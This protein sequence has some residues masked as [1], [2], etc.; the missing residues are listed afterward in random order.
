MAERF[1]GST[2]HKRLFCKMFV[3]THIPFKT[4]DISWPELDPEAT[5]RLKA[6]PIWTEA[7]NTELETGIKVKSLGESEKD[8]V[9][10]EAVR[11]NGYE[12]QRH[13]ELLLALTKRYQI[14]IEL[15]PVPPVEKKPLWAFMRV[16]YAECFDSFFAFGLFHFAAKSGFF[17]NALV[18]LFEPVMQEEARHILFFANWTAYNHV[19][20]PRWLR[21]AHVFENG[22]AASVQAVN[23]LKMALDVGGGEVDENFMMNAHESFGDI[24]PREFIEKCLSESDRRMSRYDPRLLRPRL[25]PNT[26]RF[27]LKFLSKQKPHP[28]PTA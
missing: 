24:S 10:A 14:P 16:G 17:P 9:M 3:D 15:R 19:R 28:A 26:A 20:K 21:P 23:R 2:E 8:P 1:I 27:V 22:L 25:V 5:A 7:V 12:E 13:Y 11:L 18:D 4:S 6:M